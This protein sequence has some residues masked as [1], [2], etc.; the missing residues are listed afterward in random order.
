M[1]VVEEKSVVCVDTKVV[2]EESVIDR[3]DR[4]DDEKV[5]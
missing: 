3:T 1:K 4:I 2:G 5:Y